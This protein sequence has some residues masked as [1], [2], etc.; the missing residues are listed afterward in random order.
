MSESAILKESTR[1]YCQDGRKFVVRYEFVS[2]KNPEA[3]LIRALLKEKTADGQDL[4][5]TSSV[6]LGYPYLKLGE[7]IFDL[8]K[9]APN[10]VF[11]VHL[12][13]IVRDQISRTL[14][15]S[16]HFTWRTSPL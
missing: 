15:D 13:E 10:P 9:D 5:T 7:Q 1:D 3:Y 2:R 12:Y 16:V 14:L 6:E 8:I 11:P 4:E